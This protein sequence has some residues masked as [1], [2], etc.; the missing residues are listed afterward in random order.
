MK[1]GTVWQL[2]DPL[3]LRQQR[4]LVVQRPSFMQLDVLHWDATS[5]GRSWPLNPAAPCADAAE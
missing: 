3:K 1:H 4:T 5:A 2:H